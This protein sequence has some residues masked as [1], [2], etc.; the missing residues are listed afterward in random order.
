MQNLVR[1]LRETAGLTQQEFAQATGLSYA[2]I[3]GWESGKRVGRSSVERLKS[4]AAE[5]GFADIALQL[6]SD[7]WQV[8][9]VLHPG[10]TLISRPKPGAEELPEVTLPPAS[11]TRGRNAQ[12]HQLLD[13]VLDSG[14]SDAI[15][16]VQNNLTV[17]ARYVRQK[18]QPGARQA[19]RKQ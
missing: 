1:R 9:R 12:W 11:R 10:E 18:M 19:N 15:I 13:E 2:S 4:F 17:F 14:N 7:E 3:Q 5:K 8:R 16:A 6:S